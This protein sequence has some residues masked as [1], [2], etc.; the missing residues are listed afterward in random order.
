M[1]NINKFILMFLVTTFLNFAFFSKEMNDNVPIQ[2]WNLD[3]IGSFPINSEIPDLQNKQ[4]HV[5]VTLGLELN[6][7]GELESEA[8][9]RLQTTLKAFN[10]NKNSY[11]I[12]SGGNPKLQITQAKAMKIWLQKHGVPK[13]KIIE[14]NA[15]KNTIENAIYSMNI[16]NKKNFKSVT[17]I[18]SDTHIR[19]AYILFQNVDSQNKLKFN[20]VPY[21][22]TNS[23]IYTNQERKAIKNNLTRLKS[24]KENNI[25][26]Q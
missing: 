19:R 24:Y 9:Q 10:N 2:Y 4:H 8:I 16:I 1:N 17:L 7:N 5:F 23:K 15:S 12:V 18:T 11:I 13:N 14:E 25:Y 22:K 20:L 21:I 3:N 6:S 26:Y